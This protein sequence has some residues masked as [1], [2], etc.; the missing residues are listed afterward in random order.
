M[1]SNDVYSSLCWIAAMRRQ[2]SIFRYVWT[3]RYNMDSLVK[4]L[5][6]MEMLEYLFYRMFL[7]N[8][9]LINYG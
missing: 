3:E 7:L 8:E 5:S 4:P 6:G 9:N 2:S 1:I